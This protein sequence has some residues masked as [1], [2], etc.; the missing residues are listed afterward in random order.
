MMERYNQALRDVCSVDKVDSIDL[1]R[2]LAKD[3]SVFY[4]DCHF[5]VQG[6]ETVATI[7]AR[8]LVQKLESRGG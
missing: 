3:T 4:D 1:A 2:L 8:F 5:N 6:C 7:V